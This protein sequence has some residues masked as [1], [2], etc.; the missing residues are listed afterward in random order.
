MHI[1]AHIHSPGTNEAWSWEF[2]LVWKNSGGASGFS[3]S[4]IPPIEEMNDNPLWQ[5]FYSMA[6]YDRIRVML[7]P[8]RTIIYVVRCWLSPLVRQYIQALFAT[9][10]WSIKET[11]G[12]DRWT[13]PAPTD[14]EGRLSPKVCARMHQRIRKYHT[15]PFSVPCLMS[16]IFLPL[17]INRVS[18]NPLIVVGRSYL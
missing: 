9:A 6:T 18:N 17:K 4:S 15:G 11:L 8:V 1:N 12:F 16:W 3:T 5:F 10:L 2:Y 7:E 14:L 13:L